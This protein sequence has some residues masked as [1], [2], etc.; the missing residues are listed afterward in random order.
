MTPTDNSTIYHA[1]L[2]QMKTIKEKSHISSILPRDV[3]KCGPSL[4]NFNILLNFFSSRHLVDSFHILLLFRF[5]FCFS[6]GRTNPNF[7]LQ[8]I[9]VKLK[10]AIMAKGKSFPKNVL[11]TKSNKLD[12]QTEYRFK[13]VLF[14]PFIFDKMDQ[15]ITQTVH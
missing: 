4:I 9:S 11:K 2:E 14:M 15:E 12:H 10:N 3:T 6:G 8:I 13:Q 7:V 5:Y 1:F